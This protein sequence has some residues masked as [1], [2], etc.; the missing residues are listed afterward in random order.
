[1]A[2]TGQFSLS[3]HVTIKGNERFL[4][5]IFYRVMRLRRLT[6]RHKGEVKWLWKTK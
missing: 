5:N 6:D 1:M 3:L 2:L 4:T